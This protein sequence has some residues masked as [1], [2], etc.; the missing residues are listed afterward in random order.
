MVPGCASKWEASDLRCWRRRCLDTKAS[1]TTHTCVYHDLGYIQSW[2]GEYGGGDELEKNGQIWSSG[3]AIGKRW[4]NK[5]WQRIRT[6]WCPV[7]VLCL[8]KG[9]NSIEHNYKWEN[10]K[11]CLPTRILKR[12]VINEEGKNLIMSKL[13]DIFNIEAFWGKYL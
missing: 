11:I 13:V 9:K 1:F 2:E 7:K 5:S 3:S 4:V 10:L 6:R 8:I 12:V